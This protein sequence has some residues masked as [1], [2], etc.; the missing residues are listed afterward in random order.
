MTASADG[1]FLAFVFKDK[2]I[3]IFDVYAGRFVKSISGPLSDVFDLQLTNDGKLILIETNR[4]FVLDWK[5]ENMLAQF[6][7]KAE[8]TKSSFL[9]SDNLLA[10]GQRE[11]WVTI[12]NL[13]S[14]K[15][16]NTFQY[17]KHHVSAL[18]LH[19]NGKSIAVGVMALIGESNTINLYDINTG[20]LTAQ[21][22]GGVYSMAIF[23][24][25][26]RRLVS[27]G[28]NKLGTQTESKGF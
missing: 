10:V 16:I 13:N 23:D 7:T 17:K 1:K 12:W 8:I 28:I 27:S 4:V 19:P 5:T 3:K 2:T 6:T 26:G 24:Q 21:S 15:E 14:L 20:K 25:T 9:S 11:G 22:K 18:T